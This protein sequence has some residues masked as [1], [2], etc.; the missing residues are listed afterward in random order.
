MGGQAPAFR[1]GSGTDHMEEAK[2]KAPGLI[3]HSPSESSTMMARSTAPSFDE[4]PSSA[5]SGF[6]SFKQMPNQSSTQ[7]RFD[8]K[9]SQS[10]A[11]VAQAAGT[12]CQLLTNQYR[13]KL[14]QELQVY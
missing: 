10:Q 3:P 13:L 11:V 2:F 12:P 5:R 9:P 1:K 7:R 8:S 6:E 4:T 14:S